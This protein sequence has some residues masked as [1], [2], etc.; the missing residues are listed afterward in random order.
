MNM[1][2]NDTGEI[3]EIVTKIH[4]VNNTAFVTFLLVLVNI[5][6]IIFLPFLHTFRPFFINFYPSF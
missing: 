3:R 2:I 5:D 6:P 4:Q 1:K